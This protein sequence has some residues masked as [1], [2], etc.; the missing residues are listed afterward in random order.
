MLTEELARHPQC[1]DLTPCQAVPARAIV[2]GG[3][4]GYGDSVEQ[5]QKLDLPLKL[6]PKIRQLDQKWDA[7]LDRLISGPSTH[8]DRIVVVHNTKDV[9]SYWEPA[10]A[11]SP[12]WNAIDQSRTCVLDVAC[13]IDMCT[14][15]NPLVPSEVA[16]TT[17]CHLGAH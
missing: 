17:G 14:L 2:L 9:L 4:H 5:C 12:I 8:A 16:T 6:Q 10:L 3:V 11:I 1:P 7:Y 13:C 15:L